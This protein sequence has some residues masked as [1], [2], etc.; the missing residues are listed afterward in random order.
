MLLSA[1][2]ER[3]GFVE[4]VL[5][6]HDIGDVAVEARE[7]DRRAVPLEQASGFRGGRERFFVPAQRDQTLE[8]AV[9]RARHVHFSSC[10]PEQPCRGVVILEGGPVLSPEEPHVPGRAQAL[11]PAAGVIELLG[12][13][14]RRACQTVGALQV[15]PC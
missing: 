4:P 7:V 5:P 3:E 12:N 13:P 2:I 15:D 6:R 9:Q 1:A 11:R 10:L 14:L 8:R